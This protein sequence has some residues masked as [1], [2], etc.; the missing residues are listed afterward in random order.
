MSNAPII[1]K[2]G[3]RYLIRI[4][5]LTSPAV[6][7]GITGV[8]MSTSGNIGYPFIG[9]L[10][11]TSPLATA[12]SFNVTDANTYRNAGTITPW[13]ECGQNFISYPQDQIW[14]DDFNRIYLG[15]DWI[16]SN[17]SKTGDMTIVNG[18]LTYTGTTTGG[19]EAIYINPTTGAAV[20]ADI[21]I[22][23]LA[24]NGAV[25]VYIN[26][27]RDPGVNTGVALAMNSVIALI[28]TT[29]SN[30]QTVRDSVARISNEGTWSIFYEPTPDKYTALFNG[31]EI[32]LD[33]T[34]SGHVV[35]HGPDYQ[36]SSVMIECDSGTPGGTLDNWI[37]RDWAP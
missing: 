22:H 3:E 20:R 2:A 14:W 27:S 24:A 17:N 21:D 29:I 4:A 35:P 13:F 34:D 1:C 30:V 10:T 33:W 16:Q 5:N 15:P 11:T 32:G 23:D 8:S 28:G 7:L 19:Q 12:T 6:T 18:K 9:H 26:R 36:Y 31:E 37:F 25:D